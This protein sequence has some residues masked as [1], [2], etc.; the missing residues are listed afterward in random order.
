LGEQPVALTQPGHRYAD[1]RFDRPR[2]RYIAVREDHTPTDREA[3]N[4]VV[5]VDLD[6]GE[7]TVLLSGRDFY[8][9]PR[10]DPEGKRLAWVAWDHP[11]LPWTNSELW[12]GEI[13]PD[14][15]IVNPR[16]VA[17]GSDESI[18]Q[19]EWSPAGELCFISDRTGWWNLYVQ[20]LEGEIK[21]VWE[22]DA[23]FGVPQWVF[24]LST[25]S[26][27]NKSQAI[28]QYT[29]NGVWRLAVIDIHT[30]A[31]SEP[32]DLPYT[33]IETVVCND[34]HLVIRASS[35]TELERILL[36]EWGDEETWKVLRKA[37]EVSVPAEFISLPQPIDYPTSGGRT[38]HGF[39]YP[40]TNPLYAGPPDEKPPLIVISH[41]GPTGATGSS[42][43]LSLQFWTSR[44]FAVLDVNYGGSTGYGREYRKCL[45]GQW[46]VV[47]VDDCCNGALFLAEQGLVDRD[48]LIIRGGSAG[49][50]TTLASLA[51][52]DV[53][54]AGAS[55]FGLAELEIFA[56]DTH[57]FESRY[58]DSLVAP[59][60]A[61]RDIYIERSPIK[62]MDKFSCPVIFFQ[63]LE[64][65]IVPPN[66]SEMMVDAIKEKGL[67]V[68][69]V[70]YEGEQHGFRQAKN[71]IRSLE[72]EIY[73][74]GRIFGFHCADEI[75]PVEIYNLPE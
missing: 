12:V 10:I 62:H 4:T 38:A 63:G 11:E 17:G 46:G 69:Y 44:G 52:S 70:A 26:F 65:K 5:A 39:F 41:G 23:E 28:C 50:Y 8:S 18:F 58:L 51:F 33:E 57:K 64:D 3:I 54:K 22:T 35:P 31:M 56:K 43:S 32:F 21:A 9:F 72:A 66:Q 36:R 37:G 59:Y 49:G 75:E 20:T 73:F 29:Q 7:N 14:G 15:S 67:P 13:A 53:F 27:M 24:G 68:A 60:P 40:P 2:N 42:L 55:Y 25:Y 1:G 74:Y 30:G 6:T 34:K 45:D 71:I 47:D 48:R 16:H 61:G 19:P